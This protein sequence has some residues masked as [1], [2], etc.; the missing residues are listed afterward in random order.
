MASI[1]GIRLETKAFARMNTSC[2]L[3]NAHQAV[4]FLPWLMLKT[5]HGG[6][7]VRSH[8][9]W[10]HHIEAP[11]TITPPPAELYTNKEILSAVRVEWFDDDGGREVAIFDGP[12]ALER[13]SRFALLFY[14][15]YHIQRA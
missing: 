11:V 9:W 1:T 13:A 5:M 14:G 6:C 4:A 8:A 3:R 7:A 12:R 2:V 15:R 10:E